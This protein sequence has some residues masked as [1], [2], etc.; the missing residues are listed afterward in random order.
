MSEAKNTSAR[1]KIRA[2]DTVRILS[3]KDRNKTSKVMMVLATQ[4]RV[5]VDG[6]NMVKK[7]VRPK[8][9]GEKGQRISVAAPLDISNV[10]LV[11]PGCKKSTRVSIKREGKAKQRICKRCQGVIE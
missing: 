3:G 1:I 7:H 10:Q 2:G 4:G 11:C 9:A 6:I 8:R 5:L